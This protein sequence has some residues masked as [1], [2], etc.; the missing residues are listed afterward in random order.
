[1]VAGCLLGFLIYLWRRDRSTRRSIAA[2]AAE[3]SSPS[4]GKGAMDDEDMA[5]SAPSAGYPY[6]LNPY[7]H[8]GGGH[9]Y[10]P[11]AA[12]AY[13]GYGYH[14]SS[15]GG[16]AWDAPSSHD[17][18]HSRYYGPQP[19]RSAASSDFPADAGAGP[20]PPP[21]SLSPSS[22]GFGPNQRGGAATTSLDDSA[23]HSGGGPSN[24]ASHS[25]PYHV[26]GSGSDSRSYAIPEI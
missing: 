25:Y 22:S 13:G 26:Q 20:M 14:P 7:G 2:A 15:G 8:Y 24:A 1:M 3:K 17:Y 5:E 9:P 18:P 21:M 12:F 6:G 16:S 4:E 11:Y 19:P 23:Y 10:D